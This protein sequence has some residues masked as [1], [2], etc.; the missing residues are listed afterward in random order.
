[1]VRWLELFVILSGIRIVFQPNESIEQ[2]GSW[3]LAGVVITPACMPKNSTFFIPHCTE[4]RHTIDNPL[5]YP[6]RNHFCLLCIY[7]KYACHYCSGRHIT[8]ACNRVICARH[9][10]PSIDNDIV[11]S[12]SNRNVLCRRLRRW[13][14]QK[15]HFTSFALHTSWQFSIQCWSYHLLWV[16]FDV[17]RLTGKGTSLFAFFAFI[18]CENWFFCYSLAVL[19]TYACSKALPETCEAH[20]EREST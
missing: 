15:H 18:L 9:I 12:Y 14:H 17:R 10:V 11:A 16:L 20:E 4:H 19:F 6:P 7:A 8:A 5:L 1:M 2:Q 3:S 13:L